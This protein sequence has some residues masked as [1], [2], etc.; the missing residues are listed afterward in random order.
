VDTTGEPFAYTSDDP[1][2]AGDPDGLLAV[3]ASGRACVDGPNGLD[4]CPSSNSPACATEYAPYGIGRE[5]CQKLT[6]D[7]TGLLEFEGLCFLSLGALSAV[8]EVAGATADSAAAETIA[9]AA[10]SLSDGIREDPK[11]TFCYAMMALSLGH[12][13]AVNP[14]ATG[15]LPD[16]GPAY[17]QLAGTRPEDRYGKCR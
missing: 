5:M 4:M 8:P 7:L 10:K 2:N 14:R 9:R 15:D 6:P 3:P 13:S 1:V 16:G 11:K 12:S 17:E